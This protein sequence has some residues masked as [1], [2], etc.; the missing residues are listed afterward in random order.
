[1]NKDIR[2][3]KLE[4]K[5]VVGAGKQIFAEIDHEV[6]MVEFTTKKGMQ[7]IVEMVGYA[8]WIQFEPAEWDKMTDKIFKE[9]VDLWNE[10]YG[11]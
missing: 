11:E 3:Q 1:M 7:P 9:M 6:N 8:P 4:Y 2:P 5:D 10:K